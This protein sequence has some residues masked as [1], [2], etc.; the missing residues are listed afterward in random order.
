MKPYISKHMEQLQGLQTSMSWKSELTVRD[1]LI[2][3]G[4]HGSTESHGTI[5]LCLT[6][7]IALL[8]TD[9][10]HISGSS[11]INTSGF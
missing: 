2:T 10:I 6:M 5:S 8:L 7:M 4:M 1:I 9:V 3:F 11:I